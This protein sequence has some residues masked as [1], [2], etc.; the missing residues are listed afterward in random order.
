MAAA[1]RQRR[2]RDHRGAAGVNDP[3]GWV[4]AGAR[5]PIGVFDSGVGGLSVLDALCR[6]MPGERYVYYADLA[7]APYGERGNAHV[8]ARS[9]AV[10]D[11]LVEQ[12]GIKVLVLACNT[13]TAAAI[14]AI[15]AA[16]PALPIVGVEPALK[17]AAQHSRTHRVTV[18]ATRGTLASD[19]FRRLCESV[20]DPVEF[21]LVACDGLA[22]SIESDNEADMVA[23][24]ARYATAGGPYGSARGQSDALVLGCT[25]YPFVADLLLRH[26]ADRVRLFETGEPVAQQTRRL[27]AAAGLCARDTAAERRGYGDADR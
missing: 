18:L 26:V 24:C 12:C 21:V 1:H 4:N 9:L 17:P 19:K 14:D 6:L 11:L 27:M 13:A 10:A 8:T 5:R 7:H 3:A 25:H 20:A 16:R 22:A 23:L 2:I 15:R